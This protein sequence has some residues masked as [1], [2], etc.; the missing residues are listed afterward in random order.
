MPNKLNKVSYYYGRIPIGYRRL[1]PLEMV[2]KGDL[3]RSEIS[4]VGGKWYSAF[5]L[6]WRV[7]P[8]NELNLNKIIMIRKNPFQKYDNPNLKPNCK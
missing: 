8:S 5:T 7:M 1:Q 4:G 6:G 3:C 2:A